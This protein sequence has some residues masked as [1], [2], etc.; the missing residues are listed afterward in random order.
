[1]NDEIIPGTNKSVTERTPRGRCLWDDRGFFESM[2]LSIILLAIIPT[3]LADTIA[4]VIQKKLS[5][6]GMPLIARSIPM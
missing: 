5:K 6:S 3:V 4:R 1:M 2:C